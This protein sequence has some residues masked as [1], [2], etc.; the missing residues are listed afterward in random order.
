M[1]L[2]TGKN[3]ER[4][5]YGQESTAATLPETLTLGNKLSPA[6]TSVTKLLDLPCGPL[7]RMPYFL[8]Q[9]EVA[10]LEGVMSESAFLGLRSQNSQK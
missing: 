2:T 9:E 6:Q 1:C 10:G 3:F 7:G 5:K 8:A 4:G